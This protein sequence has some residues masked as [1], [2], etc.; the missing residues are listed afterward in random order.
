MGT[1]MGT[2]RFFLFQVLALALVAGDRGLP[3]EDCNHNGMDDGSDIL[4]GVSKDC[5]RDG[6]P[7]G[8]EL[9]SFRRGDVDGSGDIDLS[10]AVSTLAHLFLGGPSPACRKA[11]DADDSG[12]LDLADGIWILEYLYLG[13][14]PP[15]S[16]FPGCDVDTTE[17]PSTCDEGLCG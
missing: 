11:A 10:D 17:D 16:P 15:P 14:S 2:V 6:I 5:N 3:S 1:F 9:R 7:D 8:C 12:V 13:G 4:T